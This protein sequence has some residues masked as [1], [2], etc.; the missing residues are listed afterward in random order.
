MFSSTGVGTATT[1]KVAFFSSSPLEVICSEV[2]LSTSPGTSPVTSTPDFSDCTFGS[3]MSKPIV[4]G[5]LRANAS[6]TGN[7]TY[8]RPTTAMR[9]LMVQAAEPFFDEGSVSP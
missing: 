1:K 8:P 7:P 9:S 4:P 5:N 2:A 6:A 3:L